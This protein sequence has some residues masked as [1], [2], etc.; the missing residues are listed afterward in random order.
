[1]HSR[2]GIA[3]AADRRR[4]YRLHRLAAD[5]AAAICRCSI[6][7]AAA[8]VASRL[9]GRLL[10][11]Q[12]AADAQA[13]ES[14][15][16]HVGIVGAAHTVRLAWRGERKAAGWSGCCFQ[17]AAPMVACAWQ[18]SS[19][20]GGL[21]AGM[22]PQLCRRL[23]YPSKMNLPESMPQKRRCGGMGA[24]PCTSAGWQRSASSR[25]ASPRAAVIWSIT[26]QGAP[27][28]DWQ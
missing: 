21:L 1:M 17:P 7:A 28:A 22:Q 12:C 15:H 23:V 5:E 13:H 3:D 20:S 27:A 18:S 19:I 11:R 25:S 6:A 14:S 2:L 8:A 9:L 10:C 24:Q 16:P 4:T 26:P